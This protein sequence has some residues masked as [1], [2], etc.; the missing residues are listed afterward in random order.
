MKKKYVIGN[1]EGERIYGKEYL[2]GLEAVVP[3]T[4]IGEVK[5]RIMEGFRNRELVIYELIKVTK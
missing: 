3:Y 5:K 4:N 1:K 2:K